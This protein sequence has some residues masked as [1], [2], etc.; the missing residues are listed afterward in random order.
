[1]FLFALSLLTAACITRVISSVGLVFECYPNERAWDNKGPAYYKVLSMGSSKIDVGQL[2][3][4]EEMSAT[5]FKI[6]LFLQLICPTA[7]MM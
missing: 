5:M 7:Y 2:L 3:I 4:V 1:M 6:T